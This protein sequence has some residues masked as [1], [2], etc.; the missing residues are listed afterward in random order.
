MLRSS[1]ALREMRKPGTYGRCVTSPLLS[2][3]YSVKSS[4]GPYTRLLYHTL[5]C[6]LLRRPIAH[7]SSLP[8]RP[9]VPHRTGTYICSS[10]SVNSWRSQI[11]GRCA[12]GNSTTG[13]QKCMLRVWPV[14]TLAKR[15]SSALSNSGCAIH[16]TSCRNDGRVETRVFS[17]VRSV[18]VLMPRQ[19]SG[20]SFS[21]LS[22]SFISTVLGPLELCMVSTMHLGAWSTSTT[23]P[24]SPASARLRTVAAPKR[25]VVPSAVR[26]VVFSDCACDCMCAVAGAW[27]DSLPRA[28]VTGDASLNTP[29]RRGSTPLGVTWDVP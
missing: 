15:D 12:L 28:G 1:S 4:S 9:R 24:V 16:T 6:T 26:P 10:S 14:A 27:A 29:S 17:S 19:Y 22:M 8:S 11:G 18:G 25:W 2:V 13:R 20:M 23:M 7:S 3:P 21:S 5:S